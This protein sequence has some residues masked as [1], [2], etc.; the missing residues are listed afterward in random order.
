MVNVYRVSN[1]NYSIDGQDAKVLVVTSDEE[2]AVLLGSAKMQEFSEVLDFW[3]PALLK[4]ELLV[5]DIDEFD[6]DY[7]SNV[8]IK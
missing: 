3:D 4:C 5:E 8:I 2:K 7:A 1:P 6:E